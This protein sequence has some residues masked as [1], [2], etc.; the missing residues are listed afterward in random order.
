MNKKFRVFQCNQCQRRRRFTRT[1]ETRSSKKGW[2]WTCSQGHS[3]WTPLGR[4]GE[5]N[6]ILKTALEPVISEWINYKSPLYDL[7]KS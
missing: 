7:P 3:L 1:L 4:V 2:L 5:L 6:L